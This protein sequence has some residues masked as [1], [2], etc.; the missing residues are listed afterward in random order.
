MSRRESLVL[1]LAVGL[2]AALDEADAVLGELAEGSTMETTASMAAAGGK[3]RSQSRRR[4]R[5]RAREGK[6]EAAGGMLLWICAGGFR[7]WLLL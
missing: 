3:A 4:R 7:G 2:V 6:V 5:G 1:T